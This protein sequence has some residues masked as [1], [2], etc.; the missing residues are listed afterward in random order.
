MLE[1][2]NKAIQQV[3]IEVRSHQTTADYM[4]EKGKDKAQTYHEN[5]IKQMEEVGEFLEELR[6]HYLK[7]KA[8]AERLIQEDE[9][10]GRE[11][12]NDEDLRREVEQEN[13]SQNRQKGSIFDESP[14]RNRFR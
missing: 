3:N 7:K 1:K 8:E 13:R 14:R 6:E 12:A 4:R 2:L 5:R 11:I 9:R 10:L